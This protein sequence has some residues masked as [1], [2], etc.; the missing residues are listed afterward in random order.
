LQDIIIEAETA[1]REGR[2]R[3]KGAEFTDNDSGSDSSLEERDPPN[4][5]KDDW[6]LRAK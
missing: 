2:P 5:P 4:S 6:D 3:P 1:E